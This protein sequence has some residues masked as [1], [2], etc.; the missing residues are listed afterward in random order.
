MKRLV[1]FE[2]RD[3]RTVPVTWGLVLDLGA[4]KVIGAGGVSLQ[5][6]PPLAVSEIVGAVFADD[7][8]ETE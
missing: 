1:A 5:P 3:G 7:E 4:R 8:T 6:L 2:T